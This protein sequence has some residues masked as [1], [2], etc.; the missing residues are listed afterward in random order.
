MIDKIAPFLTEELEVEHLK[1]TL[2]L[3]KLSELKEENPKIY[4]KIIKSLKMR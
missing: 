2:T 1:E 3:G 4:N